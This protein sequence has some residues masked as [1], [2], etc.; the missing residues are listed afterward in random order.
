MSALCQDGRMD[1]DRSM[2]AGWRWLVA[3]ATLPINR[4]AVVLIQMYSAQ[5]IRCRCCLVEARFRGGR[6]CKLHKKHQNNTPLRGRWYAETRVMDNPPAGRRRSTEAAR[7]MRMHPQDNVAI[8]ANEF[9]LPAGASLED[10]IVL[11]ERVPQGQKVALEEI[12]QGSPVRRYDVVI[13]YAAEPLA[14]GS[15]VNEQRLTMPEAPSLDDLPMA[16]REHRSARHYT[17]TPSGVFATLTVPS[18]RVI[19]CASRQRCNAFQGSSNMRFVAC[20]MNCCN[21]GFP[22]SMMLSRWNI[23]MVVASRSMLLTPSFLFGRSDTLARS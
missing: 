10:G 4:W 18:V 17:N 13:G 22:T 7:L 21:R 8:V 12:P 11:K 9:G 2:P 20:E 5:H 1:A 19:F 6:T 14:A 15:W 16:T 3:G 23:S